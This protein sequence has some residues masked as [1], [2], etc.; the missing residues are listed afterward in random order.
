[1][2]QT[3]SLG[4]YDTRCGNW[5]LGSYGGAPTPPLVFPTG[6]LRRCPLVIQ[7]SVVTGDETHFPVLLT[8]ATSCL[9]AEMVTAN[10]ANSAQA[11]GGDIRF[12]TDLLGTNQIPCQIVN[13]LQ[14]ATASLA[15]V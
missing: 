4:T 12:S 7:S 13:F 1:M 3:G 15:T 10:G 11:N 14:D 5:A 6:W 8:N 2:A 9:P